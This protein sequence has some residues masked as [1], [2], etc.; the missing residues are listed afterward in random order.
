MQKNPVYEDVVGEV[1][2][3]LHESILRALDAGIDPEHIIIDPGIGFGKTAEDNLRLIKHIRDFYDLGRPVLIGASRK[4][5]IGRVTGKPVTDRLWGS[6][7][8]A[9]AAALLGAHMVRVHDVAETRDALMVVDAIK[10][11]RL[12]GEMD[13]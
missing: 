4:Y 12:R 13:T 8:A 2:D 11:G 1:R 6:I 7:G 3:A 5:F 9:A 10:R